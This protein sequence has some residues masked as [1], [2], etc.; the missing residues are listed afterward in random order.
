MKIGNHG[1]RV[2]TI[3]YIVVCLSFSFQCEIFAEIA[4]NF[5]LKL[6]SFD[7]GHFTTVKLINQCFAI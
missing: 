7:A 1:F 4:N 3:S 6:V 2:I 5:N